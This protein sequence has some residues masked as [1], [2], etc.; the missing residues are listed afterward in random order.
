MTLTTERSTV[1]TVWAATFVAF[2]VTFVSSMEGANEGW[3]IAFMMGVAALSSAFFTLVLIRL[4]MIRSVVFVV[5]WV[6]KKR[7]FDKSVALGIIIIVLSFGLAT[8]LAGL[9]GSFLY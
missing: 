9:L 5:D 2:Y 1:L 8:A 6:N 7:P 3:T 4:F